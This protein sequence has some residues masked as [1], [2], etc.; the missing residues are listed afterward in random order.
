MPTMNLWNKFS[1]QAGERIRQGREQLSEL[2]KKNIG[3]VLASKGPSRSGHTTCNHPSILFADDVL[4][5]CI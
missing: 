1:E 4:M 2:Q 3:P 5:P